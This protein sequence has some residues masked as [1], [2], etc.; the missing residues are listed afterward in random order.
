MKKNKLK[1]MR[2][3]R[4]LSQAQLAEKSNIHLRTLQYYEQDRLDFDHTRFENILSIALVLDCN[5]EDILDDE[6]VIE[7]IKQYQ[8]AYPETP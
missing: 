3:S 2:E 6:N 1:A 7:K 5:I 4:G 8:E